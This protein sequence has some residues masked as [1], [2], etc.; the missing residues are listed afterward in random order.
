MYVKTGGK[1]LIATKSATPAQPD[2]GQGKSAKMALRNYTIIL[3][4]MARPI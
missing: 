3:G 4:E 1:I 2:R